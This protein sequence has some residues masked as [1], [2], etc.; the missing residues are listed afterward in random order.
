MIERDEIDERYRRA[1][2]ANPSRPP[3]SVRT[4]V[5]EEAARVA[6]QRGREPD[7]PRRL[8]PRGYRRPMLFGMLAA[9][10]LAGF[11]VIPRFLS[12]DLAR[13]AAMRT[14]TAASESPAAPASALPQ[15]VAP[16][17]RAGPSSMAMDSAVGPQGEPN[18]AARPPALEEPLPMKTARNAAAKSTPAR[19]RSADRGA[20]RRAAQSTDEGEALRAAVATGDVPAINAL[21][22]RASDVN[23][24]DEKGRTALMLAIMRGRSAAVDA[25][26]ARG[27]DA[28]AADRGGLTPLQAA[29]GSGQNAIADALRRAGAH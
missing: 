22:D 28:N 9:A 24:R 2:A 10:V 29:M 20:T 19:A 4:A 5:L 21:L 6:A 25:L 3:H 18:R 14:N 7:I 27:A 15:P 16:A 12:P 8:H 26:L 23:A 17:S 11:L 13:M 1:S